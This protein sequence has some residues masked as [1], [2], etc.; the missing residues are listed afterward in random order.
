MMRVGREIAA[1][2]RDRCWS[3]LAAR[4]DHLAS[5]AAGATSAFAW[6]KP[7][8]EIAYVLAHLPH[9]AGTAALRA[10]IVE[11][12]ERFDWE[13]LAACDARTFI[14]LVCAA[15]ILEHEGR[16]CAAVREAIAH[17]LRL[18]ALE[19]LQCRPYRQLE[20]Y[21]FLQR[22]GFGYRA[23][24]VRRA[25]ARCTVRRRLPAEA[26]REQDVYALTHT[27]WY[28]TAHGERPAHEVFDEH[29]LAHLRRLTPALASHALARGSVDALAELLVTAVFL[30]CADPVLVDR[31]LALAASNQADDGSIPVFADITADGFYARYHSTLV[32]GYAAATLAQARSAA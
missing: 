23:A 19:G 12:A 8:G 24:A 18:G 16:D 5:D 3:W 6:L 26:F 13:S 4:S 27:V 21:Y 25:Y 10:A 14:A 32:W 29:D 30:G 20:L 11:R 28:V 2:L 31:S 7:F 15:L 1:S 22:A 17:R 9:C